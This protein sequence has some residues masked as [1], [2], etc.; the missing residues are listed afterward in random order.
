MTQD[1][2]EAHATKLH[3]HKTA[4]KNKS[5]LDLDHY[6]DYRNYYNTLIRQ[7]K[8]NFYLENL[9]RNIKNPKRSWEL[10]KEA[11]NLSKSKSNI[12]KI[13]KDGQILTDPLDIANEFNDFLHQCG[14]KYR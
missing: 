1:L 2:L 13:E 8:Q 7:A 10:L 9:N 11:A 4:L 14:C 6:K 12:D 3:L 5:Q